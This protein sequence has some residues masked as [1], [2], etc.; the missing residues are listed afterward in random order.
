MQKV[1]FWATIEIWEIVPIADQE[2]QCEQIT[3]RK[4]FHQS[5]LAPRFL[6]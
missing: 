5:Q 2:H 1:L 6:T 3:L 4:L